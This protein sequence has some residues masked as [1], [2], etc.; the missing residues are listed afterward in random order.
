MLS[1]VNRGVTPALVGGFLLLIKLKVILYF[2]CC[3]TS[4]TIER[5]YK[6]KSMVCTS[7]INQSHNPQE[8]EKKA[9]TNWE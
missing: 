3:R 8:K 5:D 9:Q 2:K 1:G 6:L 4:M 7:Q